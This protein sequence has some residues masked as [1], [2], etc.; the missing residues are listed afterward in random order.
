MPPCPIGGAT[1]PRLPLP[2]EPE[3]Q[4]RSRLSSRRGFIRVASLAAFGLP[5]RRWWDQFRAV[6]MTPRAGRVTPFITPDGQFYLVAVDPSFRPTFGPGTVGPA[7][8]LE[9]RGLD[10][11]V[12]KLGYDELRAR[13][14]RKIVYTF[15]CIGNPVGGQ[16]IGNAEWRVIPLKELL[17]PAGGAGSVMF[18]GLDDFYSSVSAARAFD[19]RA[20]LALEMNGAPLP[21][22][23]GFPARVILP[24]LYGMKQPRWLKRIALQETAKTGSYW[25]ALGW[26]GEVP[27]K[28][29]SRLDPR[30]TLTAGEPADLTGIAFAGERGISRVEVS[31]DSGASWLDCELVTPGHAGV[32]SLWRYHWQRPAAGRYS[33]QVRA[34]DGRGRRQTATRRGSFPDGASGYDARSVRVLPSA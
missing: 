8:A 20:F 29:M 22:A 7:W 13:A 24:D 14:T 3:M 1:E 10:G 4:P 15:E 26:A 16:L 25:E 23:H 11:S 32:W 34:T 31:L 17:G 21:A 33:I 9:I 28:T 12:R 19:D 27:Q 6:G 18:N 30:D 2:V 5:L